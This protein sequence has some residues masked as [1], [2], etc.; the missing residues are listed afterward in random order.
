MAQKI[1]QR[2]WTLEFGE[3]L[4][5]EAIPNLKIEL[6]KLS[7]AR[8]SWLRGKGRLALDAAGLTFSTAATVVG[9]I[10][11]PTPL[12]P[13]VLGLAGASAIPGIKT[14][15]DWRAG[16]VEAAANG[17]HYLLDIPRR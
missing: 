8:D 6:D 11:A 2:P 7:R 1:R 17:L 4:E 12:L 9:L 10:L 14:A 3:E 16:D 13:V 15:L 5:H